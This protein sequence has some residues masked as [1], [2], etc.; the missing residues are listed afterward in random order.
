MA[1]NVVLS[2]K[3]YKVVG[4][5]PIRHDGYDK[6]TGKA[7]YGADVSLPGMLHGKVLRSPHAHARIVSI[8]TSRAEA[9]PDVEAVA[10]SADFP[11]AGGDLAKQQASDKILA[12]AKTLYKLKAPRCCTTNT[13]A[14][15][16]TTTSCRS[17]TSRLAST[18]PTSS[19]S[20]SSRPRR[21]TRATSSPTPPPRGGCRTAVS[22][23]GRAPRA[24]SR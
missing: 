4:T 2:T 21:S 8:D 3:E 12:S 20:E 17:A 11:E 14:T 7:Q 9:H 15:S 22:R 24:T 19:S 1:S 6:V 18:R 5:R 23:C 13:R 10:T 16:T